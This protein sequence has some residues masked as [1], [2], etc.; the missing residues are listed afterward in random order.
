MNDETRDLRGTYIPAKDVAEKNSSSLANIPLPP[1]AVLK[2][3]FLTGIKYRT[4]EKALSAYKSCIEEL[5]NIKH[6]QAGFNEAV[7]AEQ[8][9]IELLNDAHTVHQTDKDVR[10]AEAL[11]ANQHLEQMKHEAY[12]AKKQREVEKHN[13]DIQHAELMNQESDPVEK[14]TQSE[15]ELKAHM[16]SKLEPLRAQ[17]V[18]DQI[19]KERNLTP[20]EEKI[21][22]EI[23]SDYQESHES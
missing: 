1:D 11:R 20:E 19:R 9:T 23:V 17:A 16:E 8:R 3:A 7:L 14:M 6:A 18:A 21:L 22:D 12:L 2:S 15:K 13:V 10:D 5:S 4:V